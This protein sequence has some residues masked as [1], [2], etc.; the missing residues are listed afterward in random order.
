MT[1][2]FLSETCLACPGGA[3]DATCSSPRA[4]RIFWAQSHVV[5]G[6]LAE[7][8]RYLLCAPRLAM[9]F[10]STTGGAILKSGKVNFSFEKSLQ[11]R[12]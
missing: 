12:F 6:E 10:A 7:V 1:N 3:L 9:K 8:S 2:A 11:R 4:G 5:S